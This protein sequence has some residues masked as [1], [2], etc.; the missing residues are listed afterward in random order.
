MMMYLCLHQNAT[1]Y[2]TSV[3]KGDLTSCIPH[4]WFILISSLLLLLYGCCPQLRQ[5]KTPYTLRYTF[6]NVRWI[7]LLTLIFFMIFA[8]LDGVLSDLKS[9]A[10]QTQPHLYLPSICAGVAAI[11]ACVYYHHMEAWLRPGFIWLLVAYWVLALTGECLRLARWM[12]E[13]ENADVR[14]V[15]FS[16][17]VV[18]L[19][20]YAMLVL[21]EFCAFVVTV[22]GKSSEMIDGLPKDLQ[23]PSM[24]YYMR[25]VS[26]PSKVVFSW[27]LWLLR[28]GIKK[29]LEISDLGD[30]PKMSTSH[31]NESILE[32]CIKEEKE[33]AVRKGGQEHFSIYRI[34]LKAHFWWHVKASVLKIVADT[35][36]FIA[37]LTVN[38]IVT[39]ATVLYYN[40]EHTMDQSSEFVTLNEF[41]SNGF[42]LLAVMTVFGIVRNI[43]LQ[44]H[45]HYTIVSSIHLRAGMQAAVYNK[46][47]RL[48][49]WTMTSGALTT[50]QIT[51]FMSVDILHLMNFYQYGHY[52]YSLP[53][54][55]TVLL[56]ML[57]NLLGVAALIASSCFILAI[58]LQYQLA[59]LQARLRKSALKISDDRLKQTHEMLQ[60]MK[61]IKLYGWE[62][63]F[64]DVITSVR[65]R[66]IKKLMWAVVLYSVSILTSYFI[67]AFVTL[68]SFVLFIVF[69]G[70]PLTPAIAFTTLTIVNQLRFPVRMLTN[71]IKI[72][73]DNHVSVKR[74]NAFFI[75][76]EIEKELRDEP[77]FGNNDELQKEDLDQDNNCSK[78]CEVKPSDSYGQ[79]M[80]HRLADNDVCNGVDRKAVTAS[81]NYLALQSGPVEDE[82]LHGAH[83]SDLPDDIAIKVENGNFSWDPE[84]SS[85]FL[86]DINVDIPKGGLTMIVGQV[87]MGKSSLLSALLGEM[88]TVSGTVR[89]NREHTGIAYCAQRAWLLNASLRN[90]ILFGREFDENKFEA[91]VSACSLQPDIDILPAG[92]LTEIGEKGINLSGGQKQ[93]VSVARA[94]YSPN[95]IVILDDPFS[96]LDVHV[97]SRLFQEG[98]IDQLLGMKRT[99]VLVTHQL[100]YMKYANKVLVMKDGRISLQGT[101]SDVW[102][103][104]PDLQIT[105]RHLADT[106]GKSDGE[107]C[108]D[109]AEIERKRLQK[110]VM[111]KKKEEEKGNLSE[112]EGRL[113]EK[114]ERNTGTISWKVVVFYLKAMGYP[115][116]FLVL[117]VTLMQHSLIITRDFWLSRWSEAGE[118]LEL[119][120]ATEEEMHETQLYYIF[121][122]SGM[123]LSSAS[124]SFIA[125]LALFL[126]GIAAAKHL[127][128]RML[129]VVSKAPMRFFDTTPV[130]RILNRFSSDTNAVDAS[131]INEALFM[132]EATFKCLT[133]IIV[134]SIVSPV[135]LLVLLP[136]AICFLTL[137]SFFITSS[138]ELQ[139]LDSITKSPIYAHFSESLNGLSTIRAYRDEKRFREFLL[140]A[141]DKNTVAFLHINTCNRWLGVCLDV[142][143]ALCV[144]LAGLIPLLV[145][146]T[147]SLEPSYVGLA[148]AY[149]L[150]AS[151][152]L[153]WFIRQSSVLEMRMNAIERIKYYSDIVTEHYEGTS[154]DSEWPQSGAVTVEDVSVRYA[155]TLDPVLSNISLN[156]KPGQKIG[157]C[158]R[159]GSGKSSLTLALFRIVDMF[160]GRIL[161][162]NVDIAT[163]PL[164]YLRQRLSIIPQDPILFTGTIRFNLDPFGKCSEEDLWNSLEIAQLKAT[165]T[166]LDAGLDSLVSEGGDNFSMGQRQL[167]CLA[168]AFLRKSRILILDEATAS[169]DMETDNIVQ[170]VIS[171]E[172]SDRTIFVIAHRVTTI[173]N[174]DG[175]LVLNNGAIVEYDT[176]QNLL[177]REG[178]LF[179]S[180]VESAH[181]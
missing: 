101:P 128:R 21:L 86:S 87:G 96:A 18:T 6:H 24:K 3:C 7:L 11:L 121:S 16:A 149:A 66:E 53:L 56:I 172:F 69:T 108:V 26:F 5:S 163:L 4:L 20:L 126:S 9:V 47:L 166:G 31:Y 30:L 97:G 138:R 116:A 43:M 129:D 25:Y 84:S 155:K 81:N 115:Q 78:V 178:G 83:Q 120:N 113:I 119:A 181:H 1:S 45:Y 37:P 2:E 27:E 141:V 159:T 143:G 167:F 180:F 51:N 179:A 99:V 40:K 71:T 154:P 174:A 94:M 165:V 10:P 157:I 92:E 144:F 19:C 162:D 107:A 153:N 176:P 39:Y 136:V 60:G 173:L 88:H 32:R 41:F 123:T 44:N 170:R 79:V 164:D 63:I 156:V 131:L 117:T 134:N 8:I 175:I 102:A 15:R 103:A 22:L 46:T 104:D 12:E 64:C 55:I 28:L 133:A 17:I 160:K 168:R 90:N 52:A 33:R 109:E 59:K 95:D 151:N 161:I 118:Q 112:E 68:L 137:R 152:S 75:A 169:I 72:F 100:Q 57:Y 58:P 29:P 49:G 98:V 177:A 147:S 65:N 106:A 111:E 62:K 110:L 89:I 54:M 142:I 61:L 13:P 82:T 48:S 36:Q 70:L 76:T 50:G 140:D 91:V 35:L 127:H 130:G 34:M 135:F 145:A 150:M 73:I 122:Y 105:S 80:F 158:G 146:V 23:N 171:E 132:L 85:S 125:S 93:R 74:L 42:I 14:I 124:L 77:G 38:G 139:R 114:E 148:L 67:P